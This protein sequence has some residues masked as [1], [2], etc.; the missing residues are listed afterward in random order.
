[1][2]CYKDSFIFLPLLY[3]FEMQYSQQNNSLVF[4]HY[5][6]HFNNWALEILLSL[7]AVSGKYEALLM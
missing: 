3:K 4:L 6:P 1:M 5:V 2:A 7:V